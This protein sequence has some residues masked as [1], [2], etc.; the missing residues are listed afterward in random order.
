MQIKTRI[1]AAGHSMSAVFYPSQW[2]LKDLP[3]PLQSVH[4][5]ED[6]R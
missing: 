6:S 3:N 2:N 1:V 4:K 5:T